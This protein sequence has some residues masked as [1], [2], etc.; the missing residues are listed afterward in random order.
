[1]VTLY[2]VVGPPA[3]GKS[4]WVKQHASPGDITID[5]DAL[6]NV[7]TPPDGRPHKHPPHVQAVTKAARQ[8]AIDTALR[9]T[10]TADVY[11]IHSAPGT[12]TMDL[13]RAHGAQV[14][15]IDPGQATVM[16]RCKAE[17]PWQMMQA[18]KEWYA[19]QQTPATTQQTTADTARE[20]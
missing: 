14:I 7:L 9:H 4:T 10:D 20:W 18:A 15:T 13:Y 17:R 11:V 12:K 8:A 5:F 19:T 6:A 1:V 16:A 2:V 3:S